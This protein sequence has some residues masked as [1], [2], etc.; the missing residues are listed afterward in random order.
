MKKNMDNYQFKKETKAINKSSK[1]VT[2]VTLVVTIIVLLI[3]AGI[4]IN[5]SLGDKGIIKKAKDVAEKYKKAEI[6]EQKQLN[7]MYK[8]LT[9]GSTDIENNSSDINQLIDHIN[10]LE[11]RIEQLENNGIDIEKIYP[12][13]S[14]YISENETNPSEFLGGEWES[15]SQGRTLVGSGTGTDSNG[16]SNIFTAKSTGGEYA[17]TLS[18]N[19]IP[20][21]SHYIAV[22]LDSGV[23]SGHVEHRYK[24]E[25]TNT[26][27]LTSNTGYGATYVGETGGSQPHNNIQP[28]ITVYIWKRI[29]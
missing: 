11:T 17:H 1:G 21:H 23:V 27:Y 3:L 7:N 29:S 14:I 13:G 22:G 9:S 26:W 10:S 28:Y 24:A 25:Y 18:I 4:A 15:Y 6:E 2:L 19:E 12:V 5:L 20:K 16:T 8:T